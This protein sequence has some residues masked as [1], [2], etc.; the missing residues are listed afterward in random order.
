MYK[1]FPFILAAM[2]SLSSLSSCRKFYDYIEHHPDA[3]DTGCRVTQLIYADNPMSDGLR[4]NIT[5]NAKGNPVTLM[6]PSPR[7]FYIVTENRFRYD[8]FDRLSDYLEAAVGGGPEDEG[9]IYSPS[10]WHKYGY[11]SPDIVTD[12]FITYPTTLYNQ[13]SPIAPAGTTIFLYKFDAAGKMIATAES[14]KIP[15]PPKPVFSPIGYDARGNKD[16]GPGSN[17]VYDSAVNVYRT[18]KIWQLVFKDYSRNN[19]VYKTSLPTPVNAYGLPTR[20]PYLYAE[21]LPTFEYISYYLPYYY[22]EYAC[23]APKGPIN[24]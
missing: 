24:Y 7:Q 1:I 15:H 11:P 20:L 17:I 22:I 9:R 4:M 8:R 19:P 3:Q 5:Y 18:N 12:T 13:P 14:Q 21:P 16:Y 23:S 6:Q 10:I 2:A